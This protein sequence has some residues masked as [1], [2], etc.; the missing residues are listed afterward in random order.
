MRSAVDTS[1]G[2]SS[3]A[4]S[5]EC[6][7][8]DTATIWLDPQQADSDVNSTFQSQ[9]KVTALA[10]GGFLVSWTSDVAGLTKIQGRLY[11]YLGHAVSDELILDGTPDSGNQIYG[12]DV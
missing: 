12:Y 6:S 1:I 7:M 11:D 9:P 10:D 4:A 5:E 3:K 8:A 2:G